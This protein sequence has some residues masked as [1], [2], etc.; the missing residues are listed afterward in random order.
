MLTSKSRITPYAMHLYLDSFSAYL[1]V[2]NGMFNVRTRH[3]G[4][5]TFP[6]RHVTAILFTRGTAMSTDALLLAVDQDI[7]VLII[8]ARTH[9]PLAQV[10]SGRPGSLA[11]IRK[12]QAVF[13]RSEEGMRWVAEQIAGKIK[14]QRALLFRWAERSEAPTG[15]P[16]DIRLADR[17]LGGLE[18]GFGQWALGENTLEQTAAT[19]RG[20]EG[21]ASR[22]YF[23]QLAKLTA[24]C[25]SEPFTG[26]QKRPAYDPFNALLNYLYGMLYTQVH[27][28]QLKA[29]LDPYMGILHADQYGAKPTL[30]YDAIEPYRPWAE[31]VA[32]QLSLESRIDAS[33]FE[34]REEPTEGLWLSRQ[35]KDSV[36][37]AMLSYLNT[38]AP[39]DGETRMIRRSV[40]I[41]KNMQ[42]LALFLRDS[43]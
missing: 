36:I 42:K 12:N 9:H 34:D 5:H 37:E 3:A 11:T 31:E 8:D 19:F 33:V 1:S 40:Q 39:M 2:K 22:L 25:F 4:E 24:S 6:V 18:R 26:R 20:Q 30:V 41:D 32:L 17:V 16:G 13:S 28:A 15:F 29:G 7:P 27:L 35:G 21:T 38:P 23:Q 43:M 10:N 14:G